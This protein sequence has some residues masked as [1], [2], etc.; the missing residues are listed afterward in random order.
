M[1]VDNT[2]GSTR[3]VRYT[4][5]DTTQFSPSWSTIS[6][7]D[8]FYSFYNT[9]NSTCAGTLTLINAA[10]AVADTFAVSIPSLRNTST[11]TSAMATPRGATG[12]ARFIH[13]CPPGGVVT[14]AAIA[15]FT[16]SP[17]PYFQF[18]KFG[19]VREGSH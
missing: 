3:E 8:T 6:T 12:T 14:E 2:S 18:V 1:R 9:T 7:F 17:T 19:P 16:I 11:N 4:V 10:G 15:N 13:D 5:S